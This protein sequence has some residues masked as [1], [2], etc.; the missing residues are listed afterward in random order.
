MNQF[1]A[2]T[3][4]ELNNLRG[5]CQYV[6]LV[7]HLK[8]KVAPIL[9]SIDD[10]KSNE[11]AVLPQTEIGSP[12]NQIKLASEQTSNLGHPPMASQRH[13]AYQAQSLNLLHIP[14]V[15]LEV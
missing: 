4:K 8:H 7:V 15:G 5:L 14:S 11:R 10:V 3:S 2:H 1:R 12:E 13:P 9:R 6:L